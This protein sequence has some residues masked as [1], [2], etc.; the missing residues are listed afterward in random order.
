MLG[1]ASLYMR[2]SAMLI[3]S[4]NNDKYEQQYNFAFHTRTLKLQKNIP[5]NIS[6]SFEKAIYEKN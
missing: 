4:Y 3:A 6:S 5:I 1:V 2:K